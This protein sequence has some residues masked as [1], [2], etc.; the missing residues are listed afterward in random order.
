MKFLIDE[1]CPYSLLEIFRKYGHEAFHVKDVMRSAPDQEIFKYA[2]K[3]N[4]IIVTRDLGFGNL[5]IDNGG[6]GLL[7]SRLPFYFTAGQI[8]KVFDNF[9]KS[10]N[11]KIFLSSITVLELT[12]YR[13]RKL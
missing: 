5:F 11:G 2:N 12:R 6:F 1:D 3:N 8:T 4:M 9:L 10:V 7:L 13:K